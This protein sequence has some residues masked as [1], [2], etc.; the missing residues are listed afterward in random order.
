MVFFILNLKVENQKAKRVAAAK[1][2]EEVAIANQATMKIKEEKILSEKLEDQR[3][4]EY[5]RAR[6]LR[7]KAEEDEKARIAQAKE[8]EFVG[9]VYE[10]IGEFIALSRILEGLWDPTCGDQ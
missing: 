8:I 2:M 9:F 10:S 7:I 3:I 4:L 5:Q 1:L 6:E